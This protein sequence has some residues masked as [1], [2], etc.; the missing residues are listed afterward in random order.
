[1]G[2]QASSFYKQSFNLPPPTFTETHLPDQ[3]GKVHIVTGGYTGCGLELVRFLYQKNA[4]IY[5]AGRTEQ[6]ALKAIEGLKAEFPNSTGR[7]EFLL[8]DFS[9]LVTIKPAVQSF[10][11]KETRLDVLTNNAGVMTPPVGTKDAHNHEVQMGT[12]CL[13]PY[14]FTHLLLP[15]LSQT[16]KT[17]PPNTVRATF[18]G[19]LVVQLGSPKGGV[20]FDPSTGAPKVHNTPS[21]DYAQSKAGNFFLAHEFARRYTDENVLFVAWNPGNLRTELQRHISKVESMLFQPL[22]HEA[23]LGGYTELFAGWSPEVTKET[24][25]GYIIPWG[26]IDTENLRSDVLEGARNGNAEKFWEWCE[27]ETAAYQ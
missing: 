12:N 6:K 22:F 25:G 24:N 9:N 19:S 3:S 20:E 27:K 18:A 5:V 7:L 13:G 16:A 14:L 26:R 23:K 11:S 4:T 2:A 1:M 17:S 8:V 10:L 15:I 21:T